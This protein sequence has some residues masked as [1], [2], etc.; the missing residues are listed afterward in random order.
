MKRL[1]RLLAIVALVIGAPAAVAAAT[2]H[3]MLD[4][5][6]WADPTPST[7]APVRTSTIAP[8]PTATPSRP[9]AADSAWP[10]G[11]CV[12]RAVVRVACTAPGAL[13]IIGT[14]HHPRATACRDVPETEL[15][16]RTGPYALC[17]TTP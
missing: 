11:A 12:T 17:L 13:Q 1:A 14:I 8:D 15:T 7:G 6:E 10:L 16:R 9:D 4:D 5:T 2:A 3:A